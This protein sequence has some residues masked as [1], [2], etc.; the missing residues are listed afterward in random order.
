MSEQQRQYR[1]MTTTASWTLVSRVLGLFR[2][3]LMTATFGAGMVSSAFLLA[4]QIPNLFRRLLGAVS[5]THLTLP[6][7]YSV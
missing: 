3:Q 6:T 2:D 5:Y 7:I 4:F 1:D